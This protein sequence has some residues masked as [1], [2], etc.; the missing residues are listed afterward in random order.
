MAIF[1]LPEIEEQMTAYKAA[2]KTVS[3]GQSFRMNT[4]TVDKLWTAADLPEIRK[5]L[6]WLES[7][8]QTLHAKRGSVSVIGRPAR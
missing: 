8:K 7:E 3:L 2:L 4:G 5:T 1:T 6:S